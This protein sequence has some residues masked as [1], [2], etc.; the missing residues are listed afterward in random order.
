MRKFFNQLA[1]LIMKPLL[2]SPLHFF[3]SQHILLLSV[4]GRKSG[5]VYTTPLEYK[6]DGAE[7]MIFTQKEH[8]WWRNLKGGADVQIRLK[9]KS[10]LAHAEPVTSEHMPLAQLIAQMYPYLSEQRRANLETT[11][12]CVKLHLIGQGTD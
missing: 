2:A 9:G 6:Q 11:S 4:T 12:V 7:L 1:N 3:A 5:K 8:K 10:V